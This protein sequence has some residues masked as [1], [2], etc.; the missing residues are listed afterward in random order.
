MCRI[1]LSINPEHV[2]NIMNGTKLF[3]FRKVACKE[4]VDKIVIYSTYPVCKVVGEADVKE[5][6]VDTP[7]VVWKKTKKYSGITKQF[8]DTYYENKNKAVAYHLSNVVKFDSVKDLSS[9]GVKMAPQSF[10][11]V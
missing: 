2:E 5:V 6:I 1:L 8:F 4:D 7:E 10:V 3:E 11:Y 9:Y